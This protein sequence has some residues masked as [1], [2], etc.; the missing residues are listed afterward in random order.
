M[1]T[2][3]RLSDLHSSRVIYIY[4]YIYIVQLQIL[5]KTLMLPEEI[6]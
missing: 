3:I 4:I 1:R 6:V 5:H 2:L